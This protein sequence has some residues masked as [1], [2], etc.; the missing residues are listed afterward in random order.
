MHGIEFIETI[1]EKKQLKQ[2]AVSLKKGHN[3]EPI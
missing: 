1:D 2:L 3:N